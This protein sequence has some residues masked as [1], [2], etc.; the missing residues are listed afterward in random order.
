[1]TVVSEEKTLGVRFELTDGTLE[2]D[3][4]NPSVGQGSEQLD[5]AYEGDD[6]V[7]GFNARYLVDSLNALHEDEVVLELG[8]ALDPGVVRPVGPTEFIG[9]IMPMRI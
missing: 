3:T 6:L 7:I 9:V 2:I 8:G 1:M 4:N 5:V